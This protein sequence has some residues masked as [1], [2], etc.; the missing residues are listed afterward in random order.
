MGYSGGADISSIILLLLI[1]IALLCFCVAIPV[2]IG[3]FVWKDAKKRGMS[4]PLW[5]I[6]A[7][8]VP[9]YVG[10]IIFL[11]VRNDYTETRCPQCFARIKGSPA[12]CPSC[13][14]SLYNSRTN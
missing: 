13:G 7:L 4:A 11:L 12:F 6:V 8:F 1:G 10:L 9:F 2:A 14:A 5:T 3:V